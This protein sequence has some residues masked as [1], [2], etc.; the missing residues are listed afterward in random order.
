M[1]PSKLTGNSLD[2]K[3]HRKNAWEFSYEETHGIMCP[4]ENKLC[5]F[6]IL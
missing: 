3:D 2:H 4:L 5:Y 1:T 6:T